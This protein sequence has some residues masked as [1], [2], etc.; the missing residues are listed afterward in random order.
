Y[1]PPACGFMAPSSAYVIAPASESA[2]PTIHA[3]YTSR[4]EPTACIISAGTRK[5]PLPIMV[6]TTIAPAWLTPSSR[7]SEAGSVTPGLATG[8]G[9]TLAALSLTG[10]RLNRAHLGLIEQHTGNISDDECGRAAK[11]H[12]PG[13]RH[14]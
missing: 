10:F 6:P 5:I 9:A 1:S 8:T 3:K 11:G 13:E 7:N 4:A 12:V 2:P 14:S